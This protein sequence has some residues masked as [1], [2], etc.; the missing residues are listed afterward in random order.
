MHAKILSSDGVYVGTVDKIEGDRIKFIKVDSFQVI[1][2]GDQQYISH[3]VIDSVA[4]GIV[5]LRLKAADLVSFE[6]EYG[7]V[8]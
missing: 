7:L 3:R 1:S 8:G 6:K 5:W 2:G 4:N